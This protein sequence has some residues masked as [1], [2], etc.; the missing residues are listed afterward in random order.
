MKH[1]GLIGKHLTHSLSAEYFTR[2]FAQE[3]TT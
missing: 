2:K 1:Y 3:A